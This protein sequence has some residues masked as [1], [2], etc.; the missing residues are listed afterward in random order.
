MIKIPCYQLGELK[1]VKGGFELLS[2][3]GKTGPFR[4]RQRKRPGEKN[5]KIATGH[6]G[7]GDKSS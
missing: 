3:Q 1:I 6:T 7:R 2:V 5:K 4:S